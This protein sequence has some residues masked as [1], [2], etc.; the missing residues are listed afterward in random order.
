[1]F[2]RNVLKFCFFAAIVIFL[3]IKLCYFIYYY[4][5]GE[6]GVGGDTWVSSVQIDAI[7]KDRWR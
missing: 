2:F 6:I 1:M 7:R 4:S 5:Y 3:L